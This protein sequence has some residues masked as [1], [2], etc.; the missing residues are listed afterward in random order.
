MRGGWF[1][2]FSVCGLERETDVVSSFFF[3]RVDPSVVKDP[4]FW[5]HPQAGRYVPFTKEDWDALGAGKTKL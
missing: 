1:L 3:G 4:V 5:L 2:F